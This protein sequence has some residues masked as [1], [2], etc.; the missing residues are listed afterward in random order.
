[1][2]ENEALFNARV[3]VSEVN[4][5]LSINLPTEESDTLGGLVYTRLGK[6]PKT[7]DH[8]GVDSIEL[9][10]TAVVGR[11]I[12]Q[13]RVRSLHSDERGETVANKT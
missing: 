6:M 10:V 2:N 12:K 4:A 5:V 7:G 3:P 1:V 8:I 11:R 9:T 13:V